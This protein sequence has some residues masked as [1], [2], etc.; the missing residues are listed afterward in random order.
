MIHVARQAAGSRRNDER[1]TPQ[2]G[3]PQRSPTAAGED[4]Q[5]GREHANMKVRMRRP[6]RLAA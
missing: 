5:D 2:S 3:W 6:A 1:S 4:G